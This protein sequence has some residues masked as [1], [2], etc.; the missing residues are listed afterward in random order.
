MNKNIKSILLIGLILYGCGSEQTDPDFVSALENGIQA[1]EGFT[2]CN[3]FVRGWLNHADST[4]GLI[5]RN[6]KDSNYWNAKDAA[7]DNYPFMVLVAALTDRSMF[8]G[9]M[10]DMLNMEKKITPCIDRMPCTYNFNTQQLSKE[11][12]GTVIFGSSEYIKDGLLPLTEWL[13]D[14]PWSARM[15]ELMDDI[16]KNANQDTPFGKI[17]ATDHE[18]NG[19]MLQTLARIYWMTGEEKYLD[20]AVRLGDYFLLG[21]HHPTDDGANLRLRDHGNEVIAGLAELYASVSVARPDKKLAYQEPLHRMLDKILE[22]GRNKDGFL[23]NSINPQTGDHDENLADNWG[24]VLNAHYTVYLI[25]SVQA[26]RDAVLKAL[27]HLAKTYYIN[28]HRFGEQSDGHADAIESALNLYHRERI[29]GCVPYIDVSTRRM[30][31]MQQAD[32]VIEGWH[33]DGNFARTTVMYCT[34]KTQGTTI[35]PW[36]S[37]VIFGAVLDNEPEKLLKVIIKSSEDWNGKLLFDTPR[38]RTQMKMPFDWT[39]IN[40]FP[41]WYTVEYDSN[42]TVA[43]LTTGISQK[44]TGAQLA[45]G[46][47]VD[48]TAEIEQQITVQ[49]D[50]KAGVSRPE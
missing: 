38:H 2:R 13:G 31:G 27:N 50:H 5:P 37:T 20:W 44:Y 7:A 12:L 16:W 49:L 14:S 3:R 32:G 21:N 10:L 25:D 17:P 40:Q 22:I 28:D 24:Y 39:R 26:Y 42:Y 34:W 4:T 23:Y 45:D 6:L 9:V 47:L 48:L 41:E 1:N 29:P 15:I 11:N 8:D 30:W 36:D 35:Q 19:E 46:L 43:N 18:A 33:G